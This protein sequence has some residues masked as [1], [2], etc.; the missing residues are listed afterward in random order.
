VNTKDSRKHHFYL[1]CGI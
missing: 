1:R